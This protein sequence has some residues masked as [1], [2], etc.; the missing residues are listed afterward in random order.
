MKTC[1]IAV[2]GKKNHLDWDSHVADAIEALG[3]DVIQ[4][5]F[6]KYSLF[7]RLL[8]GTLQVFLGRKRMRRIMDPYLAARWTRA[9]EHFRPGLI[10]F[11]NANFIPLEYYKAA[12][13]LSWKP[14]VFAWEGDGP[15][16]AEIFPF[17]DHLYESGRFSWSAW[18]D[19]REKISTLPFAVNPGRFRD[20]ARSVRLQKLYFCGIWTRVRDPYICALA[21][22][23]IALRGWHWDKLSSKDQNFDVCSKTVSIDE[24]TEDYSRHA[25][26]LN[27]SQ[28]TDLAVAQCNMRTFEAPACGACLLMQ[29]MPGLEKLFVLGEEILVYDDVK[30]LRKVAEWALSHPEERERIAEAGHH[31]VVTEHTYEQRMK[32]VIDEYERGVWAQGC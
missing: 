13:E 15:L 6:N 31:R 12:K 21:G 29:K 7:I 10:F 17:I 16:N 9:V 8:R 4:T 23:P 2:V 27:I 20:R 3:H 5:Q 18:P 30:S 32:R 28:F 14:Q 26:V 22:L 24:L 25:I 1:C 11:T 19:R